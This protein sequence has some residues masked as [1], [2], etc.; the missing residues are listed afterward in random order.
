MLR[1][2]VGDYGSI[3]IG[4]QYLVAYFA[5]KEGVYITNLIRL[6]AINSQQ[7]VTKNLACERP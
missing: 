1:L 5:F 7:I 6:S 4:K 3:T 2:N